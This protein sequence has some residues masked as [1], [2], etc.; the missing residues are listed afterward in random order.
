MTQAAKIELLFAGS[1]GHAEIQQSHVSRSSVGR[2]HISAKES[3]D[4]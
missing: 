2:V 4:E 1:L 3:A